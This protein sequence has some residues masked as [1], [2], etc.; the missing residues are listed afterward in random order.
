MNEQVRAAIDAFNRDNTRTEKADAAINTLISCFGDTDVDVI[1]Y[2]LEP[3]E[4]Y[5]AYLSRFL[6]GTLDEQVARVLNY[7]KSVSA[8]WSLIIKFPHE[9]IT[10]EFGKKMDIYDF[11]VKVNIRYNGTYHGMSAIKSTY[12]EDQFYSGYVHSHCPSVR[13]DANGIKEWKS[14]CFGSGPINNTIRTLNDPNYDSRVWIAFASE[15]RQWVRT[16]STDG[17]PYFRMEHI[18]NKYEKVLS[19]QPLCP[20]RVVKAWLKPLMKSYIRAERLKIG[21]IGRQYCLGTTFTEWLIDFSTYAL[22]WGEKNNVFVPTEDTL[23]INNKVCEVVGSPNNADRYAGLIGREVLTFKGN[24]IPLKVIQGENVEHQN[25]IN[26]KLGL[27]IVKKMLN[28]I[29]YNYGRTETNTVTSVQ[30]G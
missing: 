21:Y 25:L 9:T 4:V 10:N 6:T 26:Y 20:H 16:E 15:L 18:S 3:N 29:N 11:F 22:A 27:Y 5:E 8:C 2:R 17:G 12:T 1:H 19:A 30:W 23:I 13:Q 14:M 7:L 28:V 24:P